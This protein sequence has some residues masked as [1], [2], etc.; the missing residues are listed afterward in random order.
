[1]IG[2]VLPLAQYGHHG[3]GDGWWIVMA[4][5]MALFWG[6]VVVG[7]VWAYRSLRSDRRTAA[8]GAGGT[9]AVEILDRRLAEGEI[10]VDEYRDRRAALEE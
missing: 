2:A 6:L 9:S 3:W 8:P 7:G 5:G 1:M 10:G 4:V